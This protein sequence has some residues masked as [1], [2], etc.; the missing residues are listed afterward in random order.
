MK[1]EINWKYPKVDRIEL[2]VAGVFSLI[3]L[4]VVI[5]NWDT[6]NAPIMRWI[7]LVL[8]SIIILIAFIVVFSTTKPTE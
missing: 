6:L 3:G 2:G 7:G 1:Q 4:F 8:F 5:K